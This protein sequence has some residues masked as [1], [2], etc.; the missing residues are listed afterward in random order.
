MAA[1]CAQ[2]G[3]REEL[4]LGWREE[5]DLTILSV[6]NSDVMT[7]LHRQL[8]AHNDIKYEIF[9][10]CYYMVGFL[11][12]FRFVTKFLKKSTESLLHV[13]LY[14]LL[15]CFKSDLKI[16]S[17]KGSYEISKQELVL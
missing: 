14:K 3:E 12:S 6:R 4:R 7:I 17:I 16:C 5:E 9:I 15:G 8:A 2:Q 11:F 10:V 13:Y 1:F